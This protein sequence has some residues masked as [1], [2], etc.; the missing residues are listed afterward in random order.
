MDG[1]SKKLLSGP[2]QLGRDWLEG[3]ASCARAAQPLSAGGGVGESI[4]V[5]GVCPTG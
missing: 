4:G 2:L 3:N 1:Q 5:V